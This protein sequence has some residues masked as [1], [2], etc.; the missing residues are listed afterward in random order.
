MKKFV[1]WTLVCLTL[2]MML[3]GCATIKNQETETD[4]SD[5]PPEIKIEEPKKEKLSEC[6]NKEEA[7]LFENEHVK[8]T[9]INAEHNYKK[10]TWNYLI[11]NTV[12]ENKNDQVMTV[13]DDI[14]NIDGVNV[15]S[16]CYAEIAPHQK[17]EVQIKT[18]YSDLQAVDITTGRTITIEPYY[19]LEDGTTEALGALKYVLDPEAEPITFDD[20]KLVGS[21]QENGQEMYTC[22]YA[23]YKYNVFDH[24]YAQYNSCMLFFVVK[25]NTDK[26]G[27]VGVHKAFYGEEEVEDVY[28][29]SMIKPHEAAILKVVVYNA[30]LEDFEKKANE[31]MKDLSFEFEIFDETGANPIGTFK[32][33]KLYD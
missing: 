22:Q 21:Y 13:Y 6:F 24:R 29:R 11:V 27:A 26:E 15:Y 33:E 23:G 4:N 12:F 17:G 10:N 2:L 18:N 14:V 9:A 5:I 32:S 16:E 28:A 25:N 8:V 31:V 30:S 20:L 19:Q 1:V 3:A 7:I